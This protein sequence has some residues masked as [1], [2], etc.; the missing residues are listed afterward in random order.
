M[1][2]LRDRIGSDVAK[3]TGWSFNKAVRFVSDRSMD[4]HSYAT[5]HQ[6]SLHDA[7][8]A[9]ATKEAKL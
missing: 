6:V 7:F 8:V 2:S 1:T 4:A 5:E 3:E 9:L